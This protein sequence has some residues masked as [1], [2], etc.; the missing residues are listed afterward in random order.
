MAA[1]NEFL[2]SDVAKAVEDLLQLRAVA[3]DLTRNLATIQSAL[4]QHEAERLELK[5]GKEHSR[6]S[7]LKERVRVSLGMIREL[8]V[9]EEIAGIRVPEVGETGALVHGR[10]VAEKKTAVESRL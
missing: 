7:L 2:G 1:R 8:D 9:E 5:L 4:L 10:V 3:T 6:V